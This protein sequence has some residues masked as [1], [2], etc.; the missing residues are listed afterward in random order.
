MDDTV[1]LE[2]HV[3]VELHEGVIC[4]PDTNEMCECIIMTKSALK[5]ASTL[6]SDS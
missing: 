4:A 3:S 5:I 6:D 2:L 1:S